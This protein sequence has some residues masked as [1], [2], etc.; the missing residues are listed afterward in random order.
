MRGTIRSFGLATCAVVGALALGARAGEEAGTKAKPAAVARQLE[1]RGKPWTGDFDGILERRVV[2]AILPYSRSLYFNDKGRQTGI[3]AD[4]IRGFEKWL[5][6]K[7]AKQLGNRPITLLIIPATRERL[8]PGVVDGVADVA[9]GNIT[10]TDERAKSV[11]FIFPP[12]QKP[13]KKIVVTGPGSPPIATTAD[14]AGTTVH[15]RS[16]S[17]ANEGLL[18]LNERFRQEGR[19]PIRIVHVP[20]ALE[21]EDLL[22]MVNAG[23]L[24]AVVVDDWMAAM[25]KGVLPKIQVNANAIVRDGD[26]IGWAIRKGSPGLQAEILAYM[27]E[28][29]K[30]KSVQERLQKYARQVRRLKDP[31]RTAEWKKF[32]ETFKLF[33]KYG[34]KYG[35]DPLMLA[36]QGYQESQLNQEAVSHVGAIGVMQL[37]PTTGAELQVGDVRVLESNIHAGAKYMDRLMARSFPDAKFDD[38]N[39]TLFAFG[40]Y[41]AGPG[42]IQKMRDAARKAGLDP[43]V[44]FN[45]VE[46]VTARKIGAETTT[47]VRNIYKYY[48]AYKLLLESQETARKAR[49]Q[50]AP[51]KGG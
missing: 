6:E 30:H 35:F 45:N 25:W 22:E 50:V 8:L 47:Y 46:I 44:W 41:N 31:T 29:G 13:V 2:R 1:T 27:K 36:A 10:V 20:D 15:A 34:Q 28:Q 17:S 12:D 14:L 5:N 16:V 23:I 7:Y 19:P 51:G 26:H 49:E 32:E 18:V 42:N 24:P 4:G 43:D 33:Q 48:V 11:D 37:M 9:V 21:D 38:L 39:R 3:S 40:S